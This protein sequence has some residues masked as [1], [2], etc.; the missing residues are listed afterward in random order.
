MKLSF[1]VWLSHQPDI[2]LGSFVSFC[3]QFLGTVF[4]ILT[5]IGFYNYAVAKPNVHVHLENVLLALLSLVDKQF[6]VTFSRKKI[7]VYVLITPVSSRIKHHTCRSVSWFSS[8]NSTAN[9]GT[10]LPATAVPHYVAAMPSSTSSTGTLGCFQSSAVLPFLRR[11]CCSHSY[12]K[13]QKSKTAKEEA[14]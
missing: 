5:Y 8:P 13:A 11:K 12:G 4:S 14:P 2:Q 6:S 9:A 10:V 3:F 1:S 7:C